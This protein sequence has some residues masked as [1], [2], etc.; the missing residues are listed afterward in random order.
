MVVALLYLLCIGRYIIRL[1]NC[2]GCNACTGIQGL[3]S[4]CVSCVSN[5]LFRILVSFPTCCIRPVP[6]RAVIFEQGERTG[7]L[8]MSSVIIHR[9]WH[10]QGL[11][12]LEATL[13]L[14]SC[15]ASGFHSAAE[16]HSLICLSHFLLWPQDLH[17][18]HSKTAMYAETVFSIT[19]NAKREATKRGKRLQISTL[20]ATKKIAMCRGLPAR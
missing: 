4:G 13:Q 2:L 15:F 16:S 12:S 3:M 18:I 19:K 6:F 14:G 8:T 11:L 5:S 10:D 7:S 17:L 9:H 1:V 20:R